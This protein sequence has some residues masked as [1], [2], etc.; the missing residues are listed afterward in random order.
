MSNNELPLVVI[1]GPTAS[2]K[3]SLAVD[4][5]KHCG[6]EIICADSRTIYKGIDIA[7]AKPSKSERSQVDH[8]GLDLVRP[9]DY[10]TAADFKDYA[11]E[12][13]QEI[14]SRGHVP[15]LVGGTGLYVDAVLFNFSFGPKRNV[16]ERDELQLKT[17]DEL[18]E[19]C[20]KNNIKLP[21]NV[22]NKRHLVRAIE[23]NG[24]LPERTK[25]P[26][27]NSIIVG[28][29]TYREELK[30]RISQRYEDMFNSGVIE[31]AK[32][33]GKEYGW[34]SEAM[35]ANV[36]PLIHKYLEGKINLIDVKNTSSHL[37]WKLAKRQLTWFRRNKFIH[38]MQLED[39]RSYLLQ[40]IA[41][42][43]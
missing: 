12:K 18:V 4:V 28:I 2:G 32:K 38:W 37:D 13:I 20:I 36:Y 42:N 27:Y 25:T 14:R 15:F 40:T 5:A 26:R 16:K 23:M 17:V 21:T 22:K 10:F 3:T 34:D 29:T 41:I 1:V 24:E 31:E 30:K 11:E 43:E 9:G 35:K 6:G 8:W 33:L 19:Y 39:A 7:S